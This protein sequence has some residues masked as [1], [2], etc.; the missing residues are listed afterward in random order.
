MQQKPKKYMITKILIS[1]EM[2]KHELCHMFNTEVLRQ[3]IPGV[4]I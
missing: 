2:N 1:C 3:L 4:D